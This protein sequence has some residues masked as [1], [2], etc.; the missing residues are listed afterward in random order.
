MTVR[1]SNGEEEIEVGRGDYGNRLPASLPVSVDFGDCH[2]ARYI[3]MYVDRGHSGQ[4][5]L[6]E[7]QVFGEALGE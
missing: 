7:L 1:Q 2:P 6:S 5:A 3:R 4:A